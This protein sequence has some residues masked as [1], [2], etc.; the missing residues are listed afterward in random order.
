MSG[1]RG[2]ALL[3]V[4]GVLGVAVTMAAAFVTLAR[5]ERRASQ[6]RLYGTK[7][8]LLARSGLEDALARMEAGQDPDAP[9]SRYLGEDWD[10][11]D[12]LCQRERSSEVFHSSH[13]FDPDDPDPWIEADTWNCPLRDAMRP[14]FFARV[15]ALPALLPVDGRE[16]GFSG[17]LAGDAAP[18]GNTYALHLRADDGL[19]VNGGDL[20]SP[21]EHPGTYDT[22]L[23]RLLGNFI[24]KSGFKVGVD[25]NGDVWDF[26]RGYAERLVTE[27]PAGGW[28]SLE[29]AE[30]ALGWPPGMTEALRP[31]LS[32]HAWVDKKVIKPNIDPGWNA[33]QGTWPEEWPIPGGAQTP[34]AW[35]EIKVGKRD[36]P[37]L[38]PA[39]T[40][41]PPSGIGALWSGKRAF[42][43]HTNSYAPDFERDSQGAVIGR[44]PVNLNWARK[45][46]RFL[47]ALLVGLSGIDLDNHWYTV[48]ASGTSPHYIDPGT[49]GVF[50]RQT[51]SPQDAEKFVWALQEGITSSAGYPD[52]DGT[53]SI[54]SWDEFDRVIELNP[55]LAQMSQEK[56]DLVKANFNPNA[57]L[58]KFNPGET[59]FRK[60]DKSDLCVYST[61]FSF[62]S[63]GFV[64]SSLGRVVDARGRLL[65]ERILT[66]VFGFDQVRF[67]ARSEFCAAKQ[68]RL[69][70]A[71]D[72]GGFRLPGDAG[73]IAQAAGNDR[74]F[75]SRYPPIPPAATTRGLSLQSYP[76][77]QWRGSPCPPP[78]AYDGALQLATTET[79]EGAANPGLDFLASWDNSYD[80]TWGLG[81]TA[82][83]L[84]A[85]MGPPS[86]SLLGDG[87]A[88][89]RAA[90]NM[91]Y[92][93]G[94]YSESLRTPGYD[95]TQNFGDGFQGLLSMWYKPALGPNEWAYGSTRGICLFNM[96][97][98]NLNVS[99]PPYW[100]VMNFMDRTQSF[101][102]GGDRVFTGQENW[103]ANIENRYSN[104]E[105][106]IEQGPRFS[107]R[108]VNPEK[109]FWHPHRWYLV[110]V[111]W[112]LRATNRGDY[113]HFILNGTSYLDLPT[114]HYYQDAYTP[115]GNSTALNAA[116][117]EDNGQ[118]RPP[119]FYLGR[120]GRTNM[121][122]GS[123]DGTLDEVAI[124]SRGTSLA[125]SA[126]LASAR[127]PAGRFYKED[128]A[129]EDVSTLDPVVPEYQSCPIQLPPGVRIVRT[130]WTLR[131]PRV[132]NRSPG[133][134]PDLWP[135]NQVYTGTA[136]DP[137]SPEAAD[138]ALTLTRADGSPLLPE[139][140]TRS[141]APV[142]ADLP[143]GVFRFGVTIRPRLAARGLDKANTPLLES[144]VFDD[145]T[146][147][148]TSRNGPKVLSWG[149][150]E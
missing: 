116:G 118:Q 143:D 128:E 2:L 37:I 43:P 20:S 36:T 48:M 85:C 119:F 3:V 61:E 95:S 104:G 17:L 82:C 1:R 60:I 139:R 16:R 67:T 27:R 83:T 145:V 135:C 92:P 52:W 62:A 89:N 94:C 148:Y 58:N 25:E 134:I 121:T 9:A 142:R 49:L 111:Q 46:Y 54:D 29:Q 64:A 34:A 10:A 24:E 117:F 81:P 51:L 90:L 149:S 103:G 86:G 101:Q 122:K 91:I 70:L 84:D 14:S 19:Y 38:P 4:V 144:P 31:I 28:I 63:P 124:F 69:D 42:N 8:L 113:C 39:S 26:S 65:A 96:V 73:F 127:F 7:A 79:L 11:D 136:A 107:C 45:D 112:N 125:E 123:A 75:G 147:V 76:E 114:P 102:I 130:D 146:F 23:K 132:I 98:T 13:V 59:L 100:S 15:D 93:D 32:F 97:R 40:W 106:G 138:A 21:G 87:P 137:L 33:L 108:N 126:T 5:L 109:R 105:N 57:N 22:V 50:Y 78:G 68:G 66:A 35:T 140:L 56:K 41:D 133:G 72:E 53:S 18:Q 74:T 150:G 30:K 55:N 88:A 131:L 71:G 44:A 141:G 47:Y 110:T 129:L 80:A 12:R 99:V 77:P 115:D 120:R 6:Q